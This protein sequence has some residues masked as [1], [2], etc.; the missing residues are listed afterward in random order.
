MPDD[1][2][3]SAGPVAPA[4]PAGRL[5]ETVFSPFHCLYQDALDFHTQ[6]HVRLPRSEG[7]AS[8]LARAAMMLYLTSAE[9]LVHQAAAELGRPELSRLLCDPDRPL[10]LLEVW[11]LLPAVVAESH[12]GFADPETPPWPQF[13]E[14][15]ALR[16][17]WTY[18]GP[19]ERRTAYYRQPMPEA[20][21]EPLQP[22]EIP[23]D[24]G[25]T[26]A[27]LVFPRTGLPRDPYAIRPRHLDTA[28]GV[29]DSAIEAL[30][31]RLGGALT[32]NGRHRRE[33]VRDLGTA[34]PHRR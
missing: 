12:P 21:F 7:E 34:G 17:L 24:L 15:L 13:A 31:R 11:R 10:A 3:R 32:R 19:A 33:P 4:A 30:D 27:H 9:A 23:R 20:G 22:H 1:D 6:S 2:A 5:I 25:I 14:L 16:T 18:P 28:R 29:L 8:R 26:P